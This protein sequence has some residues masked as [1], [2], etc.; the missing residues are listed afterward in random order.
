MAIT[1]RTL[2]FSNKSRVSK[3]QTISRLAIPF[4]SWRQTCGQNLRFPGPYG[5]ATTRRK[6]E[7]D[8]RGRQRRLLRASGDE[9]EDDDDDYEAELVDDDEDDDEVEAR[10]KQEEDEMEA[11]DE[12]LKD[13]DYEVQRLSRITRRTMMTMMMWNRKLC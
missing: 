12:V 3:L 5:F 13:S 6:E 4:L 8:E 1:R 2:T 10:A 11:N 9:E 7:E